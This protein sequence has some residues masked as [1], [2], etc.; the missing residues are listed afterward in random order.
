MGIKRFELYKEWIQMALPY[1]YI[2]ETED[3]IFIYTECSKWMI[4][5]RDRQRFGEYGVFHLNEA[6]SEREG[7]ETWHR[8]RNTKNLF[9]ALFLCM[10]HDEFKKRG[11]CEKKE[12][13]EKVSEAFE[14]YYGLCLLKEFFKEEGTKL[15]LDFNLGFE[16]DLDYDVGF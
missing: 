1:G 4:D 7:T 6:R 9:Y 5:K 15:D 14:R 13:Y 12:D 16:P 2:V 8:Q 11:F 10:I 3:H